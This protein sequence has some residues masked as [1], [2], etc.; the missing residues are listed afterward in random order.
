MNPERAVKDYTRSAADQEEALPHD[1]RPGPVLNRTMNYLL[2]RIVGE[3]SPPESEISLWY[4][5]LWNRTRAIRKDLTQQQ[6]CDSTC[7][8]L[9]EKCM[10]LHIFVSHWMAEMDRAEFDQKINSGMN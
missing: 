2:R 3:N 5:F 9:H 1:L 4:D 6:I 10:R 8:E 7:V